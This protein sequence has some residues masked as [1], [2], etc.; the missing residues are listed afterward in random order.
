M[1]A[2]HQQRAEA[3][4]AAT[5]PEVDVASVVKDQTAS[6]V[7]ELKAEVATQAKAA[8]EGAMAD[9]ITETQKQA[10]E[11][12]H[13][14][15][16]L[17]HTTEVAQEVTKQSAMKALTTAE[18]AFQEAQEVQAARWGSSIW[19]TQVRRHRCNWGNP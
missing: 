17:Q 3:A 15:E 2:I 16:Q 19:H 5:P 7:D 6:A 1:R 13:T 10:E 11:I 9:I 4:A 8:A 14:S 12:Q 18:Q